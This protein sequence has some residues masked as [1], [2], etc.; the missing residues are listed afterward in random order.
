[1]T[2]TPAGGFMVDATKAGEWL[3]Y[4]VNV[5]Q[6]GTYQFDGRV[7]STAAGAL[8]HVEMDGTNVSG[9]VG[10][11]ATAGWQTV[12]APGLSLTAGTH[13]IRLAFDANSGNGDVGS[14]NWFSLL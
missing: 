14:W 13:I 12:D 3:E 11:P 4:T 7:L 6:T 2:D 9:S 8:F 5:A 10:I 1:S